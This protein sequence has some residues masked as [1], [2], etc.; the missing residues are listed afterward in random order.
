MQLAGPS[1]LSFGCRR[2]GLYWVIKSPSKCPRAYF[3]QTEFQTRSAWKMNSSIDKEQSVLQNMH[4][5]RDFEASQ[6]SILFKKELPPFFS[7]NK[8]TPCHANLVSSGVRTGNLPYTVGTT[9]TKVVLAYHIHHHD[10]KGK[11][12]YPPLR[13]RSRM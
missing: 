2:Q 12:E 7:F 10:K 3:L 4:Q 6:S 9:L 5:G 13:S 8:N 11:D 1:L